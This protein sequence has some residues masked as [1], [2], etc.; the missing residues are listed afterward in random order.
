MCTRGIRYKV[1]KFREA[2]RRLYYFDT[3][4]RDEESVML[5]TTVA[6]NTTKF[7]AYDVSRAKLARTIQKHIGRPSTAD[8]IKFVK[9]NQIPNCP[10]TVQDIKTAEFIGSPDLGSLKGKQPRTKLPVVRAQSHS[11]P[12][13]IMQKYQE[14]ML[15]VDIMKV[16]G[17]PFLNTIS[18]HIKFGSAGRLDNMKNETIISHFKVIM[19]VYCSLGFRVTIILADNQ[20]ESMRG[21]IADLGA[22]VNVVSADEHVPEI[23]R[24]N[25]TI[26]DRVRSQYNTLPFKRYPPVLIVELV[27][28][29]VFCSATC[30]SSRAASLLHR[31]HLKSS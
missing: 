7:S 28:S 13:G 4:E 25:R 10:I 8:F 9:T 6:V 2:T 1:L 29:Q 27:Y 26:K 12:L 11:I 5:V 14:V 21:A 31:V 17:I 16:C 20:F 22:I 18:R 24:F 19:S 3:K 30:L 23:E 15:S